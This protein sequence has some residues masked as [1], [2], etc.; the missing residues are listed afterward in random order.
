VSVRPFPWGAL[1]ST[2]RGEVAATAALRAWTRGRA[3][4]EAIA[5]ALGALLEARVEVL[6]RRARETAEV[7]PLDGGVAVVLAAPDDA[8]LARGVVVEADGALATALVARALKRPAPEIVDAAKTSGASF[9]GA[10]AA[11]ASAVARRTH[12]GPP[13]RVLAAGPAGAIVRDVTRLAPD[14]VALEVTV[15]VDDDAHLARV[16]VPRAA[17]LVAPAPTW[18]ARALAS[19]GDVTLDLAV[20]ACATL[21]T[22]AEV[23]SLARG[24]AWAPGAWPLARGASGVWH[25]PVM[26]AV[27]VSDVGVGADLGEDGR[28][29]LRGDVA[30]LEG[31]AMDESNN[32][33]VDA[34]GD[35]PVVVRVEIGAAR[36]RARE[37]AALG[38]GDV[39][40]LG[41]RIAEPVVLRIGGVEVARGDLVELDGEVAVRIVERLDAK[42]T[43]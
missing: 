43:G 14:L 3:R 22:A 33:L 27:G 37:W 30:P 2:S 11:I 24:D 32:A 15:I 17:A 40:A 18:D 38:K 42:E 26:L 39:V 41:R 10:I 35:V 19:L 20:V 34:V 7:P 4:A 28:L 5:G 25:G 29:V 9:A 8:K 12:A 31:D 6:L 1:D 36:M 16:L 13:L 21:A 23:G